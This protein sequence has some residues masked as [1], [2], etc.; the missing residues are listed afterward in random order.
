MELEAAVPCRGEAHSKLTSFG[1][2]K[3][4][5]KAAENGGAAA[6]LFARGRVPSM[7]PWHEAAEY[8]RRAP[9][10]AGVTTASMR[11]RHEAAENNRETGVCSRAPSRFHEA[12][13][14]SRGEPG[15][16]RAG[17]PAVRGASMRPRHEAAENGAGAALEIVE[18][19]ASMRPRHE[20]A[21]NA[22]AR[23][24]R[25]PCGPRFHEAAARSRGEQFLRAR[26]MHSLTLA[27]M[28]PRHEAAENPHAETRLSARAT[29]SMRPR[30]EAAENAASEF[31]AV[32]ITSVLP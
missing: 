18:I 30:H 15:A 12:A 5:H 1:A 29:A 4:F 2:T 25:A 9:H 16:G 17:L 27:S 23:C 20:A 3:G 22:G 24:M 10:L 21:E 13:A 31:S 19:C 32:V 6:D 28:R 14:R 7:R 26:A 8:A 11:P